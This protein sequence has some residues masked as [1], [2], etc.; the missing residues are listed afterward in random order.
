MFSITPDNMHKPQEF[1]FDL[2]KMSKELGILDPLIEARLP[3]L[4]GEMERP[5]LK[6]A[7]EISSNGKN[8]KVEK[9][10]LTPEQAEELIRTLVH[11]SEK[12][13]KELRID[14][15]DVEKSLRA[16]PEALFSL[17]KLEETGGEPQAVGIEDDEIIFEDRSAGT[18]IGRRGKNF[19]EANDQRREFGP[20]VMFQSLESY[21]TMPKWTDDERSSWLETSDEIRKSGQAIVGKCFEVGMHSYGSCAT[22]LGGYEG[23]AY[24]RDDCRGWRASLRVKKA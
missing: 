19:D 16:D 4:I 20:R 8:A 11:R 17:Q 3:E 9:R 18:P 6:G 7:L 15:Y 5:R 23:D 2:L 13:Y 1:A 12:S 21:K 22:E 24:E 14:P 10:E